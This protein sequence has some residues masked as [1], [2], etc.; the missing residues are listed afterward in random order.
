MA[1]PLINGINYDWGSVSV[2][3]F[4]TPVV[5][6]TKITYKSKQDKVNNYGAGASR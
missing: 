6:I 4:G 3:L 2:I 5:G 1:T